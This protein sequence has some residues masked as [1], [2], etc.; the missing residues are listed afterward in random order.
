MIAS[1]YLQYLVTRAA[2]FEKLSK[3]DKE[4]TDLKNES[5]NAYSCVELLLDAG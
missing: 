4:S 5:E 2:K 3:L 1:N